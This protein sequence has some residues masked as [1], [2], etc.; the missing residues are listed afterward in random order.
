MKRNS[1]QIELIT[2]GATTWLPWISDP[3]SN[4]VDGYPSFDSFT[5]Q[6]RSIRESAW[7]A[8]LDS[9]DELEIIPDPTPPPPEP[10]WDGFLTPF[11]SPGVGIYDSIATPVQASTPKTQEHWAN[12]RVG[13][14]NPAIRNPQWLYD[15]W[16][17]LKG[18]LIADGNA[19]SVEAIAAVEALMNQYN[20]LP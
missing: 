8:F 7:Q 17:H 3:G 6:S 12:I 5:G 1:T 16:E 10:D 14:I 19:L 9:G 4:R 2:P 18:L 13:L 15:S 20:L 11:Y